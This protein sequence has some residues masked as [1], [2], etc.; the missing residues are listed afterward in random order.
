M[1][2]YEEKAQAALDNLAN[3]IFGNIDHL[4]KINKKPDTLKHFSDAGVLVTKSHE[5][6][7]ARIKDKDDPSLVAII[8]CPGATKDDA[9]ASIEE[10]SNILLLV[11]EI[12]N[13]HLMF[14]NFVTDKFVITLDKSKDDLS[15]IKIEITDGVAY[16]FI[17]KTE[18]VKKEY[19]IK[20]S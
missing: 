12:K 14:G 4:T 16:V 13:V 3:A 20:I 10:R 17:P 2:Y 9:S 7:V 19:N 6:W 15:N 8:N 11:L 18:P 5:N 1:S